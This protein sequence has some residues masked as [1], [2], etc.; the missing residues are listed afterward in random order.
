MAS[1][2]EFRVVAIEQLTPTVREFTLE[3]V[4]GEPAPAFRPGQFLMLHFEHEGQTLQRS[5]SF[6]SPP[7]G[8]SQV[9]LAVAPVKNGPG[10]QFLWSLE[11]GDTVRASGPYGRFVLRD[12]DSPERIVLV[13][14][15][16]GIAPYRAMLPSLAERGLPTHILLGVRK[17]EDALYAED[18]REFANDP[19]HDFTLFLSRQSASG[20]DEAS[21]YVS[22]CLRR[23]DV[24][25]GRDLVFLC[26][27]PNM[28]DDGVA[29]LKER[30]FSARQFRREKYL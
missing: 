22:Q 18:F 9:V 10:T 7:D 5:Y 19:N 21:G 29:A 26:G 27:N 23:L 2:R 24:Q 13:G 1:E 4:S 3:L 30:G 28:V 16:T 11:A 25:P 17:R 20:P 15:G 8:S 6:A 14:T 12:T